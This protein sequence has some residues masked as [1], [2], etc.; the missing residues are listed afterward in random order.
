MLGQDSSSEFLKEEIKVPHKIEILETCHQIL[1]C[2]FVYP[3][4]NS[5]V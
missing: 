1:S 4:V 5:P 3:A 2:E